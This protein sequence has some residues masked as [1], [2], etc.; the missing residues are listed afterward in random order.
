MP[1]RELP[2]LP[3]GFF[4]QAVIAPRE[5]LRYDDSPAFRRGG[6]G[7]NDFAPCTLPIVPLMLGASA[8]GG[9]A[10]PLGVVLGLAASFTAFTVALA[11]ALDALGLTTATLRWLAIFALGGFGLALLLPA[12]GARMEAISRRWP[13]SAAGRR[14]PVARAPALAAGCFWAPRWGW[15]GLPARGRSWR[16]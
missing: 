1:G 8:G 3:A 11:A 2:R 16:R 5:G 13:G 12:I 9:R 15:F 7:A 10:R 6:R 14:G 4:L